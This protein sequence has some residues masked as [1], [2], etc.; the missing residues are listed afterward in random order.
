LP[1]FFKAISDAAHAVKPHSLIELCPCGTSYSFFS[2]PYFNMTV[3]SDP[4]SSWQ[5]RSKGKSLR[6]LMGDR[7]P[8]FGDHVELSDG[9]DDFASTI[10]VGGVIGTQYRWPPDDKTAPR[11]ELPTEKLILSPQK[12]VV[13]K[14]WIDIYSRNMLSQ[15]EYL[16]DLY[17]IGFDKPETHA[18]RKGDNLNFSFFAKK[19]NGPL[20]F[21]GLSDRRYEIADYVNGRHLGFVR[22]PGKIDAAFDKYLLVVAKPAD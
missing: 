9:G 17:D 1:H 10:G 15:G 6:A 8:Y 11:G 5:V 18:I 22:G 19:W 2:M 3:A 20:E 13:W 21:R 14:K 7:V 12:E 4:E 16:G